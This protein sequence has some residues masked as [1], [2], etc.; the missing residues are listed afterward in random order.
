MK[1]KLG[2]IT[3]KHWN[4][5]D[6]VPR[7]PFI[8]F[9][10]NILAAPT[11]AQVFIASAVSYIAV[12]A[13]T[14]WALQALAPKPP[15]PQ[16]GLLFNT[17]DALASQEIVYGK[18]RKGGYITYAESTGSQNKY[19]HQFITIAGHEV[20]AITKIYVQDEEVTLQSNAGGFVQEARWKDSDNNSKLY[21][22]KFTGADNQNVSQFLNNIS[23][24]DGP[25][26]KVDGVA[27]SGSYTDFKG[28]GIAC[29]Y[30]RLEYDS[31]VFAE[32]IPLI[33]A[34]VE[35][36]KVYDPRTST[37]AYSANAALCIRDYLTS[38]MV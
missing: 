31:N 2:D 10:G 16:R 26:W 24:F 5:W 8:L 33:T 21:I 23:G 30:V 36:K 9:G 12:S 32:G 15:A 37:T 34:E 20:N 4:D 7:D 35:G 3:V 38:H 18:I 27:P 19:L 25:D 6:H 13:V 14:S 28:E 22:Y 17:R 1:Y 11:A 29:L